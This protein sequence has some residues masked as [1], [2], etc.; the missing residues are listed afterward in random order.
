MLV[1]S[2]VT[3]SIAAIA[4]YLA[5]KIEDDVFKAG[6]NFTALTFLLVTLICAPWLLKLTLVAVPLTIGSLNS[7][8]VENFN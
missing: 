2:L 1:L 8:S 3:L 6:I 7:W 4:I 5:S